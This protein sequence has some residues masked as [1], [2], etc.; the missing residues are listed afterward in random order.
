MEI[1]ESIIVEYL[2]VVCRDEP[3][4][5]HVRR[6]G[7]HL[8]AA[9]HSFQAIVASAEIQ[10]LKFVGAGGC[11]LG[12]LYIHPANPITFALKKFDQVVTDEATR[13]SDKKSYFCWTHW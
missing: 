3:H 11:E 9:L 8:I 12:V 13:S 6:K 1:D 7:E 5:T 2:C 4:A 10:N